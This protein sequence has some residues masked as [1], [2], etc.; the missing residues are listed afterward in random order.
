VAFFPIAAAQC[1][2]SYV[3]RCGRVHCRI[4]GPLFLLSA[5]YLTNAQLGLLPS[6]GNIGFLAT[7]LDVVTLSFLAEL[8]FGTYTR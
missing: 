6:I 8:I 5:V 4:T 2:S 1:G 7:V 3:E